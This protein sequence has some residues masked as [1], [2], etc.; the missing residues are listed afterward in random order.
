MKIKNNYKLILEYENGVKLELASAQAKGIAFI[1]GENVSEI[2]KI[3][4]F[5]GCKMYTEDQNNFIVY[6]WK[7]GA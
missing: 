2:Y 1:I 7:V 6:N 5:K 3:K 4:A